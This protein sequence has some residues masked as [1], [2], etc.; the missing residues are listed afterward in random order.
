METV[1]WEQG[2]E[3]AK[4][5]PTPARVARFRG[6]YDQKLWMRGKAAYPG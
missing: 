1:S 5:L 2:G 6:S 3:Q 4:E